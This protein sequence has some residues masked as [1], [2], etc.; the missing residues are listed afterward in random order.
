ALGR[1]AKD[2]AGPGGEVLCLRLGALDDLQGAARVI[3]NARA[4]VGDHQALSNPLE[5]ANS[6]PL[7][8]VAELVAESRLAEVERCPGARQPTVIGDRSN[9]SQMTHLQ[10]HESPPDIPLILLM[11]HWH[12]NEWRSFGSD[13]T[14]PRLPGFFNLSQR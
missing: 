6:E 8:H 4:G 13:R 14:N 10:N 9:E 3:E 12:C 7:F 2:G 1:E 5:Q 11:I